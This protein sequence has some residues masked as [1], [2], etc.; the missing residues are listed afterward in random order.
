[1]KLKIAIIVAIIALGAIIWASVGGSKQEAVKLAPAWQLTD[2]NG[3]DSGALVDPVVSWAPDSKSLLFEGIGAKY[4]RACVY[5]W[6]VGDKSITRLVE[7]FCPN[8]ITNRKFLYLRSNPRVVVE[9]DLVTGRETPVAANLPKTDLWRELT[10]FSYNAAR[11]SL[12]LRFAKFTRYY[13]PGCEEVDLQGNYTGKVCRTT[14]GGILDRS[15]S[16]KGDRTAVILG[17]L[18][19]DTRELRISRPGEEA[20]AKTLA[21]NDLGAVAWSPDGKTIVFGDGN[22]VKAL[23]PNDGS[24]VTVA[25]FPDK[26]EISQAAP[27][28]CR[29]IWSPDSKYVAAVE[30]VP[31]EANTFM[32]LYVLDMS[33]AR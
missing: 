2:A 12:E 19:G 4:Y 33:K 20:K 31:G 24:I 21:A 16:P 14:G 32:M 1:M 26:S 22:R 15:D 13:E 28:V 3:Y 6:R 23:N 10:G 18:T 25:G 29:L 17:D 5:R 9:N 27:F 11:K 30:L 8:Y 7:G